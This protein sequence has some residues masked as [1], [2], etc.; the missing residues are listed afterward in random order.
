[1]SHKKNSDQSSVADEL[2]Q[3]NSP[4]SSSSNNQ[5]RDTKSH[6]NP[7]KSSAIS[8][9]PAVE[10]ERERKRENLADN[11]ADNRES[12]NHQLSDLQKQLTEVQQAL[13]KRGEEYHQLHESYLRSRADFENW[14]KRLSREKEDAVTYA[15][16]QLLLDIVGVL[17]NFE[18]AM[19]ATPASHEE[20]QESKGNLSNS[21]VVAILNGIALIEREWISMLEKKWGLTRFQTVG[22]P[23]DPNLHEAVAIE[24]VEGVA[25]QTV[26]EE[27]QCGYLL[28]SRLLRPAK[29][30][31]HLPKAKSPKET[32]KK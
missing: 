26:V 23:F 10:E 13:K 1:M 16:S 32:D 6:Y 31:V 29:V 15:N 12:S 25:H 18:R 21:E 9:E 5:Q 8:K 7:S 30:K 3:K 11:P 22:Q 27:F 4:A 2:S 14:R 20:L 28:R 17:D 24:E 19:Q